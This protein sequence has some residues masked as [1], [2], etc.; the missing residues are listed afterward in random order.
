MNILI[1][2]ELDLWW[3]IKTSNIE[4]YDDY[5]IEYEAERTI[6]YNIQKNSLF[7]Q[8]GPVPGMRPTMGGPGF[9]Q[10]PR[11]NQGGGTMSI[12]MPLYT[13]GIVIFFVYTVMKIIFKKNDENPENE[14]NNITSNN[15]LNRRLQQPL[16]PQ[17]IPPEY[18]PPPK[19]GS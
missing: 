14:S 8:P 12:L 4:Y 16:R 10:A 15:K 7:L 17:N 6:S 3:S 2:I 11:G 18:W 19:A 1:W 13:T 9:P 5:D